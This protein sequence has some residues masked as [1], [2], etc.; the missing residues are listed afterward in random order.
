MV[1]LRAHERVPGARAWLWSAGRHRAVA[2]SARARGASV[3]R[4]EP[5]R[6]DLALFGRPGAD[7]SRDQGYRARLARQ[8]ARQE[9]AADRGTGIGQKAWRWARGPDEPRPSESRG[10]AG[11]GAGGVCVVSPGP[12]RDGG[13][14]R[15]SSRRQHIHGNPLPPSARGRSRFGTAGAPDRDHRVRV[16]PTRLAERRRARDRGRPRGHRT[17]TLR[18]RVARLVDRRAAGTGDV[19]CHAAGSAPGARARSLSLY[20][21]RVS[22]CA[23]SRSS[24]HRVS[25]R[26]RRTRAVESYGAMQWSPSAAP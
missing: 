7:A 26:R 10:A 13:R 25:A 5:R 2:R 6:W 9:P 21:A 12:E 11:V 17:R 4:I 14:A 1:W 19:D 18:R 20:G 16:V 23:K 15:R 3:D 22:I 8:G 24:S